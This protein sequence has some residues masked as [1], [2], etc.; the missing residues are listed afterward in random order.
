MTVEERDRYLS[1]VYLQELRVSLDIVNVTCVNKVCADAAE[2]IDL[3]I[4]NKTSGKKGS[5]FSFENGIS[6]IV[7]KKT[8]MKTIISSMRDLIKQEKENLIA[9]TAK[10][11]MNSIDNF[12]RLY[13]G[14]GSTV[15]LFLYGHIYQ[16]EADFYELRCLLQGAIGTDRELLLSK[17]KPSWTASIFK[18]IRQPFQ[19]LGTMIS[20]IFWKAQTSQKWEYAPEIR[21]KKSS[22]MLKRLDLKKSTKI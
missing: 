5:Y 10:R 16:L 22:E 6:K 11:L 4:N 8:D 12:Y 7:N 9:G 14:N 17:S 20:T 15:G 18:V 3:F 19:L 1:D 2:K 13:R 21:I